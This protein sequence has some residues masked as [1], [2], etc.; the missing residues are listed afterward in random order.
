MGVTSNPYLAGDPVGKHPSFVGRED[1]LREVLRVL[2]HP[3]QNAITLYGQRRIGKTS[4]LQY[5]ETHL[6]AEGIYHPALF[7]LMGYAARPLDDVLDS[8][9]EKIA[10]T[11]GQPKPNLGKKP[12]QTF[13]ESWL[14][15]VLQTLPAETRLVL[16]MDE[17]DVQA[18]VQT[19][20]QTKQDF[21][22]Y[23]RNLRRIEPSRLKFVFVLGRAI[24]D[25]DIIAQGLL[26]DLPSY[27]VSLL[28][29][30]E[31]E[32][33]IRLSERQGTLSWSQEAVERVWDLTHGHP[34]LVQSL[35][36]EIWERTQ[37]GKPKL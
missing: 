29:R 6:S 37:R 19:D 15:S 31:A 1:V 16:L 36:S 10:Q 26:K 20:H 9:A 11:L 13:G 8:L 4:I 22:T 18:D 32:T 12:R 5:L 34:L 33:L 24:D 14:P 27:R 7:D 25:L 28:K 21:F 35:C 17:F 2:H 23:L 30:K 3:Q